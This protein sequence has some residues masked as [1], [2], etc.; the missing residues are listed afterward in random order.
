MYLLLYIIFQDTICA[1][2]RTKTLQDTRFRL[3]WALLLWEGQVSNARLRGLLGIETV[4]VSRLLAAFMT[5]YPDAVIW[6]RSNRR[7]HPTHRFPIGFAPPTLDEYL[8]WVHARPE[9]VP[10][11]E[12]GPDMAPTLDATAFAAVQEACASG[13]ALSVMYAS[14]TSPEGRERLIYPHALAR[15]GER[16]LIRAWCVQRAGYIDLMLDRILS[17]TPHAAAMPGRPD[18]ALWISKVTLRLKAHQALPP[19]F[20]RLTERYRFSGAASACHEVRKA[21]VPYLLKHLRAALDPNVEMP[22]AFE[23][24]VIN[25]DEIAPLQFPALV[26]S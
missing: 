8:S 24:Q 12:E 22:P 4:M 25:R 6:D 7:Y 11:L 3:I 9:E 17:V 5:E 21:L 1:M 10:W 23:L 20:A 14:L 13:S 16:W 15:I 19:N 26:G 2:S 18:D